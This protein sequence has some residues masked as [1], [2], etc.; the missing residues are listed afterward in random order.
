MRLGDGCPSVKV[1]AYA[2]KPGLHF[3]VILSVDYVMHVSL[4]FEFE[5]KII[6]G[7]DYDIRRL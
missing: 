5:N 2:G 6:T 3:S 7:P 4:F 1:G